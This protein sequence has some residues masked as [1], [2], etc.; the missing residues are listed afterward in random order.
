MSNYGKSQLN[1]DNFNYNY[2]FKGA[3]ITPHRVPYGKVLEN[4]DFKIRDLTK[5]MDML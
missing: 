5:F 1:L 3:K 2:N 4:K